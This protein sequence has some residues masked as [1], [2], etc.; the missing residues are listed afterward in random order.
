M[1]TGIL[2]LSSEHGAIAIVCNIVLLFKAVTIYCFVGGLGI[3]LL[4]RGYEESQWHNLRYPRKATYIRILQVHEIYYFEL[5]L[6]LIVL[7]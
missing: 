1:R 3:A 7:I 4:C 6:M 5:I 2:P